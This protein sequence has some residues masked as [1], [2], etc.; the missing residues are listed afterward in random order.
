MTTII[1]H[2]SWIAEGSSVTLE[3]AIDAAKTDLT[4]Y[5]AA[6]PENYH[7]ID[8]YDLPRRGHWRVFSEL[9]AS[10]LSIDDVID[11]C[12]AVS[13]EYQIINAD[14]QGGGVYCTPVG[15]LMYGAAELAQRSVN[16]DTVMVNPVV[17]RNYILGDAI[18]AENYP[19]DFPLLP[20]HYSVI[21]T[22]LEEA[23]RE[24]DLYL[25]RLTVT[26]LSGAVPALIRDIACRI[27]RYRL[28]RY[29]EGTEAE[30][31]VYRDYKMDIERLSD[32]AAGKL[33][34]VG[35]DPLPVAGDTKPSGAFAYKG[36]EAV[37]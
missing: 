1:R 20:A 19:D 35:L 25:S 33:P 7:A 5:Q 15:M 9:A 37:F 6:D 36:P 28:A 30:S 21:V 10:E 2:E 8:I 26:P 24:I 31:R 17:L 4:G 34:V 13:G 22:A 29:E 11:L 27:A 23:S 16:I 18:T 3:S 12:C 32:I 14:T